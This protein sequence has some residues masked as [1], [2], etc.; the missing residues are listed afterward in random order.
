MR[1]GHRVGYLFMLPAILLTATIF[2]YPF[3]QAVETSLQRHILYRP[4]RIGFIGFD[5]Y[6][7]LIFG[8]A[9]FRQSVVLTAIFVVASVLLVLLLATFTSALLLRAHVQHRRSGA[10]DRLQLLLLLPFLMTPAV[11]G[12]VFRVFIWDYDTGIAN[13][14]LRMIGLPAVEWLTSPPWAMTAVIFT[15]VWAHVPLAILV[16]YNAMKSV[17]R[18]PY[19]AAVIDGAGYWRQFTDI[20]LPYVRPQIVFIAIMQLT[21]SFRQFELIYLLTG[22]GPG[23]STKV[24]TISIFE[25][26]MQDLNFGYGNAMGMLSLVLVGVVCTTIIM[27]F[28]RTESVSWDK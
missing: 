17:P 27:G 16:L 8:D 3:Y 20:T 1:P 18:D 4:D 14:L 12:T 24:L 13:W 26:G 15:E 10:G 19:E 11:A 28:A 22:G 7:R 6:A 5:N 9:D 23:S 2:I 25:T 21:L